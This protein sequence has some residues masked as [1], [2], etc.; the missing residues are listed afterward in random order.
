MGCYYTVHNVLHLT[1]PRLIP[2][3]APDNSVKERK[4][5]KRKKMSGKYVFSKALKELRFHHCQTSD[6]SNAIRY[7]HVFLRL[8]QMR[9]SD[10]THS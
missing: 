2:L 1:H 7:D 10:S 9:R 8:A 3:S 5:K 4:H 6:H